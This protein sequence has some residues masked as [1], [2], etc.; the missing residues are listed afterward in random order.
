MKKINGG[1]RKLI[2]LPGGGSNSGRQNPAGDGS[3]RRASQTSAKR[4]RQ[5]GNLQIRTNGIPRQVPQGKY[6]VGQR[7]KDACFG[8][9]NLALPRAC[10]TLPISS[11]LYFFTASRV[12]AGD[13]FPSS[14][15]KTI[16][17]AKGYFPGGRVKGRTSRWKRVNSPGFRKWLRPMV[18]P[19]CPAAGWAR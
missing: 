7:G 13:S 9:M 16:Q 6:R 8:G 15:S 4:R 5:P 12:V 3:R 18:M 19:S 11:S 10:S 14:M 17:L 1:I 2:L